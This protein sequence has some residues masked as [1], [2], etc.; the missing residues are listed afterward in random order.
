MWA[1]RLVFVLVLQLDMVFYRRPSLPGLAST[2]G[3]YDGLRDK[4]GGLARGGGLWSQAGWAGIN[5]PLWPVAGSFSLQAPTVLIST[6]RRAA[7]AWRSRA[8]V[9]IHAARVTAPCLAPSSSSAPDE[10]PPECLSLSLL[11]DLPHCSLV[12]ALPWGC[13]SPPRPVSWLP[14]SLAEARHQPWPWPGPCLT[15]LTLPLALLKGGS[16][17]WGPRLYNI[18]GL[19]TES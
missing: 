5:S 3:V 4:K 12:S 8:G 7:P 6:P 2:S 14:P 15:A 11:T 19:L 9:H 17:L 16:R 10:S 13:F 1:Q 18:F